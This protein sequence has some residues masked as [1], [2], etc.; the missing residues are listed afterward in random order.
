LDHHAAKYAAVNYIAPLKYLWPIIAAPEAPT[1]SWE[2]AWRI[3]R[4]IGRCASKE[5]RLRGWKKQKGK[6][7]E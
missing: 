5:A 3:I 4:C 2:G 7:I 6:D 1:F